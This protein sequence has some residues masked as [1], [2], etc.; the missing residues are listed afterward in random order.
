GTQASPIFSMRLRS[1][2]P[3]PGKPQSVKAKFV[4]EARARII[5]E[6][7]PRGA[8]APIGRHL[9][10][11]WVSGARRPRPGRVGRRLQW[12]QPYLTS[13]EVMESGKAM[14]HSYNAHI[15][16]GSSEQLLR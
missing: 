11:H 1:A 8:P 4:G 2:S 13:D 9:A 16:V 5:G 7:P 10:A 3:N 15:L 6:M 12:I 14:K